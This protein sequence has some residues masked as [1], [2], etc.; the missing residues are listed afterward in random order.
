M[1]PNQYIYD[2]STGDMIGCYCPDVGSGAILHSCAFYMAKLVECE[3][4]SITP[5]VLRMP[6]LGYKSPVALRNIF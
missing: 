4:T 6:Y 2:L 5:V 1:S 3:I